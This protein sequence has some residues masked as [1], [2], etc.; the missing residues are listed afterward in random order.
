MQRRRRRNTEVSREG[1][2][3]CVSWGQGAFTHREGHEASLSRCWFRCAA[4]TGFLTQALLRTAQLRPEPRS[5]W[6]SNRH[7]ATAEQQNEWDRLDGNWKFHPVGRGVVFNLLCR[8]QAIV[9]DTRPLLLGY[10]F[11]RGPEGTACTE[12]AAQA[13]RMEAGIRLRQKQGRERGPLS[14]GLG[15]LRLVPAGSWQE[16]SLQRLPALPPCMEGKLESLASEAFLWSLVRSGQREGARR[17]GQNGCPSLPL[18][19]SSPLPRPADQRVCNSPVTQGTGPACT[20]SHKDC[21]G[22]FSVVFFFLSLKQTNPTSEQLS[23]TQ[24][25]PPCTWETEQTGPSLTRRRAIQFYS[26]ESARAWVHP[27][28][29]TPGGIFLHPA[30]RRR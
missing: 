16:K 4:E 11:C 25:L 5:P 6:A 9:P 14:C 8:K 15:A 20:S 12:L 17:R 7:T 13:R 10:D 23:F 22:F 18:Y 24:H 26:L 1:E 27:L 29:S 19:T 28:D 2:R 21:I 30:E 3:R